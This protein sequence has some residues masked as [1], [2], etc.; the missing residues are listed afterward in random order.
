MEIPHRELSEEALRGIVESFVLREGTDYGE[1]DFP[2]EAKVGAVMRQ[3]DRGEAV[4]VFDVNT[5]TAD[6]VVASPPRRRGAIDSRP[7]LVC[8][9]RPLIR[10]SSR[11]PGQL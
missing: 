4:I 7:G 6:V 1:R 3:L 2:L 8:A 9:S 10:R 11:E 5:G